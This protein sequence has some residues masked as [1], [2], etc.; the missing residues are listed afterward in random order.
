VTTRGPSVVWGVLA[1]VIGAPPAFALAGPSPVAGNAFGQPAVAL[2]AYALALFLLGIGGGALAP[3]KRVAIAVG[4]T[5]PALPA[6]LLLTI[7]GS[8]ATYALGAAFAVAGFVAAWT[9][10]AVGERL[11]GT[12]GVRRSSRQ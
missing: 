10:T 9:G 8:V 6:F 5:L 12:L 4:L 3:S 2:A 7:A 1:F 11:R